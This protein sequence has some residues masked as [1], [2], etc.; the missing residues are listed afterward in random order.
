[1]KYRRFSIML[2]GTVAAGTAAADD[3]TGQSQLLCAPGYVTHCSSGGECETGPPEN[4]NF[5]DFFR[6]DL[7][8]ELILPTEASQDNSQTPI[9]S[10]TRAE[11]T[12]FLQG[13]E[14]GRAYSFLIVEQTGDGAVSVIAD[15]ETATAF[16]SCTVD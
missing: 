16:L 8:R 11:G 3:V 15:G 1:M 5:L 4:Y 10:L 13:V 2:I 12:I 7:D 14:N 9:Q 6:I